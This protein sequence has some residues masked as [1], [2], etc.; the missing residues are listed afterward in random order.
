MSRRTLL[1]LALVGALAAALA[2]ALGGGGGSPPPGR[3]AAASPDDA[4]GSG[5]V[6][7][8]LPAAEPRAADPA[9][10]RSAGDGL[11]AVCAG[12]PTGTGLCGI[13]RGVDGAA[14][15]DAIVWLLRADRDERLATAVAD[16][17]GRFAFPLGFDDDRDLPAFRL[18]AWHA[19]EG[20]AR[21]EL[22]PRP[23]A[24]AFGRFDP[25]L[26]AGGASIAGRVL[27]PAGDPLGGY[28]LTLVRI[29]ESPEVG[30]EWVLGRSDAEIASAADGSFVARGLRPG[31]YE[32]DHEP[33]DE[34]L[35]FADPPPPLRI[36]VPTGALAVELRLPF[37][38]V[39]CA[40]VDGGREV[41]A[42]RIGL[43]AFAPADA[44]RVEARHAAG[45]APEE[46][47]GRSASRRATEAGRLVAF[48]APGTLLIAA[49]SRGGRLAEGRH[50]VAASPAVQELRLDVGADRATTGVRLLV[51][52]PGGSRPG[53]VLFRAS[54]SDRLAVAPEGLADLGSGWRE[55]PVDGAIQLPPGS[56]RVELLGEP[57][58]GDR[59]WFPTTTRM[60][61]FDWRIPPS[62]AGP[63]ER[64]VELRP[65]AWIEVELVADR[66]EP[67]PGARAA[68]LDQR[69][70]GGVPL[71]R[72]RAWLEGR[73]GSEIGLQFA[74]IAADGTWTQVRGIPQR[75]GET[76]RLRILAVF[77]PGAAR[78]A[79]QTWRPAT[80]EDGGGW[81]LVL[82]EGRN[83]VR[84]RLDAEGVLHWS[85][86]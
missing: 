33:S 52:G 32:L 1:V 80:V 48:A 6:E 18:A 72:G 23:A 10:R 54:R 74:S 16:G 71:L 82:V 29:D 8:P 13:V 60:E 77:E 85:G 65:G 31:L 42:E 17:E 21:P 11:D 66:G 38:Q 27:G 9:P 41:S 43:R 63:V 22:V 61:V 2:V 69:L 79:L 67:G 76:V 58:L 7:A 73:G 45:E 53:R 5:R 50:R 44:D 49:A 26:D 15:A 12:L 64:R 24:D 40:V 59:A 19:A 14:V 25:V 86:R 28:P 47:D 56:L 81:P 30:P 83:A 70:P 35:G 39:D 78:L 84:L 34:P 51:E 62:S 68:W 37:V 75:P 46:G 36:S 4:G 20:L 55:L 57:F 3:S